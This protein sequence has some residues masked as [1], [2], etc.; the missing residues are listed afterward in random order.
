MMAHLDEFNVEG[1]LS[2]GPFELYKDKRLLSH[3]GEPVR[4]AGRALDILCLLADRAGKVV[5][6]KDILDHVW[7]DVIVDEGSLRVQIA[8]LR[9]CL[10]DGVSGARYIANVPGRG[11]CFVAPVSRAIADWKTAARTEPGRTDHLP[12]RLLRMVGRDEVVRT[13]S[14]E[15]KRDRFIT[16]V[17]PGGIGK[18]TVAIWVGH[19]LMDEFDHNIWFVDFGELHDARLVPTVLASALAAAVQSDATDSVID[20]LRRKRSLL[21]LDNCEHVADA[22]ARLAERIFFEA[23]STYILAT[24]REPL[25]V[26]GERL[27]RL[28]PLDYPP[29]DPSLTAAEA[30][31]FPA[32]QLFVDR[33]RSIS[34]G[35]VLS[36]ADAPVVAE[37]CRKVDGIALAIEFAAGRAGA[38]GVR[39]I[40]ALLDTRISML[41]AG[42]RTAPLRHQTLS[43]VL[44][45][46]Y[47]LLSEAE[48]TVL[49]CLSIFAGTFSLSSAIRVAA[50]D[51]ADSMQIV[52]IIGDLVPKSLISADFASHA[53]R[54]RL[55]DT[56]RAFA[57][58]K[59]LAS[60]RLN[61]VARRHAEF[62]LSLLEGIDTSVLDLKASAAT[63]ELKQHVGDVR[64]A[65]EWS[66]S[67]QGDR[68]IGIA[69]AAAAPPLLLALSLTQECQHWTQT[70]L[71]SLD[72]KSRGS[73]LEMVLQAGL[74]MSL[75]WSYGEPLRAAF[76]RSI[77]IAEELGETKQQLQLLHHLRIIQ[78]T[79]GH[80]RSALQAALKSKQLV[81]EQGD[82]LQRAIADCTLG[83]IYHTLGDQ[84]K[85]RS[86][87]EAGLQATSNSS[88]MVGEGLD[89]HIRIQTRSTYA[90]TLWLLGFPE[91]A[92]HVADMTLQEALPADDIFLIAHAIIWSS[93]V[94]QW[95]DEWEIVRSLVGRLTRI[96]ERH[97]Y[98]VIVP[99][100]TSLE[101]ILAVNI[102]EIDKGLP[103]LQSVLNTSCHGHLRVSTSLALATGLMRLARFEEALDAL[104]GAVEDEATFGES[105]WTSEIFRLKGDLFLRMPGA[106]P[107]A[108][109]QALLRSS[110]I[111]VRQSALGWQLRSAMSMATLRRQQGRLNEARELVSRVRG[112]FT[113]GWDTSDLVRSGW[114]LEALL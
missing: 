42:R 6:K 56:T 95:R 39:E 37:I 24:S 87:C 84:A 65:L 62:C 82:Q 41:W 8:A 57:R 27:S 22:V 66:F 68:E 11:Y 15:I 36:D 45:W 59:L 97:P 13:V 60:G 19:T 63:A 103:L 54:Y 114:L 86:F 79:A 52:E 18:T 110:E 51:D 55:L 26:E 3:S 112:R 89:I 43:A 4:L 46:S 109:E 28:L 101:G 58:D 100:I 12:P 77:E 25:R 74:G 111:A 108:A 9:K 93:H 16:I 98:H 96:S 99:F 104:E 31:E 30:L 88:E 34:V 1:V 73:H 40:A 48:R 10:G 64:A 21:I 49:M 92:R 67:P 5:S 20:A 33:V 75:R 85:S 102:G 106:A 29:D 23:P 7:P 14:A 38:F 105:R 44:D 2:F 80:T 71:R 50:P 81:R 61:Q 17:G 113:E 83:V 69:L 91:K 70:A 47:M 53:P 78:I 94:Y 107:E 32:A 35:F 72:E 76:A 90:N